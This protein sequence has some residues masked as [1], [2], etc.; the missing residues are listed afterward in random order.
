MKKTPGN[1]ADAGM[2]E[3]LAPKKRGR[4]ENAREALLEGKR[5]S[6]TLLEKRALREAGVSCSDDDSMSQE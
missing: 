5:G 1:A 4:E 3:D 6:F 2:N